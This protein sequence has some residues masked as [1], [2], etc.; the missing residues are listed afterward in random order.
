MYKI[1]VVSDTHRRIKPVIDVMNQIKDIN[2]IFHLGDMVEDAKEI[3]AQV[4]VPVDYVAGNCDFWE[5]DE[6]LDKK[7]EILGKNF[8]LTHGHTYDV[9]YSIHKLREKLEKENWD[10]IFFGHTHE[11]FLEKNEG[12]IIMN[13]GS[14]SMPRGGHKA[15]FGII[16]IDDKGCIYAGLEESKKKFFKSVDIGY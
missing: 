2:H 10:A 8:L 15:G 4:Q 5:S 12:K 3:K 11:P 1:L 9:K 13:P 14:I 7:V 6:K 16:K